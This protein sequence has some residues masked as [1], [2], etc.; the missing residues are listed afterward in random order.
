MNFVFPLIFLTLL[1]NLEIYFGLLQE[2]L[3]QSPKIAWDQS[4]GLHIKV[5]KKE[6]KQSQEILAHRNSKKGE[7]NL[8]ANH[9][10]IVRILHP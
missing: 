5:W 10:I 2:S 4:N 1:I 6:R 3:H 8:Q 9:K 7:G